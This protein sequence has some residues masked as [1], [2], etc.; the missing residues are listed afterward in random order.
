MPNAPRNDCDTPL[1]DNFLTGIFEILLRHQNTLKCFRL[2]V[3]SKGLWRAHQFEK[4]VS[5]Y[6]KMDNVLI[7]KVPVDS[8]CA[9]YR[10]GI[11]PKISFGNTQQL[12]PFIQ[13][14]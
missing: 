13:P 2:P 11:K 8:A 14:D 1:G 5:F 9:L 10:P 12:S 7:I 4:L 6:L 3:S